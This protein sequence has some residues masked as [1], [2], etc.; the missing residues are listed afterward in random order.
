MNIDD[1]ILN[2][3]DGPE[4]EQH[5]AGRVESPAT[6]I[7]G[8]NHFKKVENPKNISFTGRANADEAERIKEALEARKQPGS[9]YDIVRFCLDMMNH[10]EKDF[11]Q[12]FKTKKKK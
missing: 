11:F 10:I 1:T 2:E 7:K 4:G 9:F 3:V 8:R 12:T 6:A 5:Q